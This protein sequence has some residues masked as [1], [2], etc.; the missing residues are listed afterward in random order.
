[1]VWSLVWAT[2]CAPIMFRW[3]LG[4]F[5]R[6]TAAHRSEYIGGGDQQ[7]ARRAFV[8]RIAGHYTPGVQREIFDALYASG[9]DVLD[10][11]IASVRTD[12]TPDAEIEQFIDSFTVLSRG[13]K[14]DFDDEK[15]EE[16]H[17]TFAEILNDADAQI[18]FSPPMDVPNQDGIVEVQV[19]GE[20][21]PSV[22]HEITDKLSEM[23][24]DVIKAH[25]D[26]SVQPKSH[27]AAVHE[28][29]VR[30]TDAPSSASGGDATD[31]ARRSTM[32]RR[33]TLQR[34]NTMSHVALNK[35]LYTSTRRKST[36]S[37]KGNDEPEVP[38]SVGCETFY[39]RE[40]DPSAPRTTA[41]RR[42]SVQNALREVL[43]EHHLHGE[44]MVRILHSSEMALVHTVPKLNNDQRE[45]VLVVKCTGK[46][47][48][49]LLHEICDH[50]DVSNL[51]V[52]HAEVDHEDGQ[53]V[54][55]FYIKRADGSVMSEKQS[56]QLSIDI[57]G[58]YRSHGAEG[59]VTISKADDSTKASRPSTTSSTT[60]SNQP[61]PVPLPL[62]PS[63]S[64]SA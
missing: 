23:G 58:F 30:F 8:I 13:K 29:S 34:L 15:L 4:V 11:S 6:A 21:H 9:V 46:H 57:D 24:L 54:N 32:S 26:Q 41:K 62:P 2:V 52:L 39:A 37:A 27:S 61:L 50:F 45:S 51:E 47:H 33:S 7:Y 12:D 56:A 63:D 16:M 35:V 18:I 42:H 28:G 36:A 22:L 3:A 25:V 48:K 44:V 53:D 38:H 1:V 5:D 64:M 40:S 49:E 17:H 19:I 20:H 43:N 59:K 55:I 31:K 60:S 10:A 14:K